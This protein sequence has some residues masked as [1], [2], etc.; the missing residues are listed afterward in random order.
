VTEDFDA[1]AR[2]AELRAEIQGWRDNVRFLIDAHERLMRKTLHDLQ[3]ARE[4]ITELELLSDVAC[5][6]IRE[7]ERTLVMAEDA[8]D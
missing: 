5:N 4:R 7:L 1:H 8:G 2:I 6:R 3:A